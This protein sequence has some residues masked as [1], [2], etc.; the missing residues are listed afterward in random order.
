MSGQNLSH[1]QNY[2]PAECPVHD[3]GCV[4]ERVVDEEVDHDR[5]VHHSIID[6]VIAIEI[7]LLD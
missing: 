5:L 7:R 2:V 4:R 6:P 1:D 3:F